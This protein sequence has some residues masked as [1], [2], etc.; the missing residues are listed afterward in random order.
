LVVKDYSSAALSQSLLKDADGQ[1]QASPGKRW[2]N[3]LSEDLQATGYQREISQSLMARK[4]SFL[5][6]YLKGDGHLR[7]YRTWLLPKHPGMPLWQKK[8]DKKGLNN[9]IGFSGI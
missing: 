7:G 6:A 3:L 1:V 4:Q 2:Q 5:W 9:E 8:R